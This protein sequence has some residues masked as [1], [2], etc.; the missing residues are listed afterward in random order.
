MPDRIGRG[1]SPRRA[2]RSLWPGRHVLLPRRG[3]W[4]H[5]QRRRYH[6]RL[7]GHSRGSHTTPDFSRFSGFGQRPL[8]LFRLR[9]AVLQRYHSRCS[10]PS[11]PRRTEA[12]SSASLTAKRGGQGALSVHGTRRCQAWPPGEGDRLKIPNQMKWVLKELRPRAI[13]Q[14]TNP[15]L[16]RARWHFLNSLIRNNPLVMRPWE[17]L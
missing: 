7:L 15:F 9:D 12:N 2:P 1:S 17:R 6:F 10:G 8:A 4:A 5:G 16:R 14:F 11:L 3:S 13:P